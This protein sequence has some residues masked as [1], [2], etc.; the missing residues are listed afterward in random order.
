MSITEICLVII[1]AVMVFER[2]MSGMASISQMRGIWW[3]K[4]EIE[5]LR[6]E[7][8]LGATIGGAVGAAA[9]GLLAKKAKAKPKHP[10]CPN[11]QATDHQEEVVGGWHCNACGTDWA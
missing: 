2:I 11:C 4:G 1:T 8:G 10:A 7:I 5:Q 3:L 9:G 6:A